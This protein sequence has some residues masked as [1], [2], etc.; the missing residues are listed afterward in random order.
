MFSNSTTSMGAMRA[1]AAQNKKA[2]AGSLSSPCT[3]AQ[4]SLY[5]LDTDG[6]L[7]TNALATSSI[8]GDGKYTFKSV[9][10]LGVKLDSSQANVNYVVKASGCGSTYYRPVT[11]YK[12]QDIS[13]V[14]TLL[15]MTSDTDETSKRALTSVSRSDVA[16]AITQLQ[17]L[18]ATSLS[19]L[20]DLIIADTSKSQIFQNL[21]NVS[22][23]KLKDIPPTTITLTAPTSLHE[24]TANN[25]SVELES[26]N[27]D[28][29]PAYEWQL[30]G[31][32]VATTATYIY[33]PGQNA[34]GSHTLLFKVGASSSGLIDTTK[35][36]KSESVSLIVANDYPAIAPTFQMTT[37][38]NSG[39]PISTRSLTLTLNTGTGLI[40]CATF[41]LLAI[42]EETSTAPAASDFTISCSTASTQDVSYT[43][44]SAG[45]GSKTLR[46]WAKDAAGNVSSSY[47]SFTL[48]LDTA[49]PTASITSTLA[50]TNSTSQSVTFVANDNGG[51][52]DH[53]LCQLDSGS[54]IACSS[55]ASYSSLSAGSHSFT[56]KAVDTAGNT[57]SPVSATWTVDL[58]APTLTLSSTPSAITNSL[59]SLFSFSATDSGGGTVAG[60]QCKVDS[61][62]Y[63]SCTSPFAQALTAGSHTVSVKALDSAGNLSNAQTYSWLIDVTAPTTS[64]ASHPSSI[65]NATTA[66]FSFSGADTGGAGVASYQCSLD[67]GSYATCTSPSAYSSLAAGSHSFAVKAVDAAGNLGSLASFTWTVDLTLPTATISSQP[68]SLIN[69]SSANFVFSG[70]DTGGG[71]VASYL[72]SLDSGSYATCTSPQSYSGL[73][74]G[75]HSFA[76][77]AVDTAGN[78]GTAVTSNWTIDLTGPAV[79]LSASPSSLNNSTSASLTF[80]ATDSGGSSVASYQCSL[81]SASYVTCSSP[82]AYSSLAQGVHS[83]AIKALDVLGNV[84]SVTSTSWTTDL[85]APTA[86]ISASPQ[87]L[88]NSTSADFT[89]SGADTGGGSVASYL[90]SLDSGSYGACTSPATYSS[91]AAGAHSFAVK[92][93]D[94]A[95]NTGTAVTSNW[96]IDLTTPL[97]SINSTPASITNAT[98]A[99][100]SFSANPPS[101]GS[102][103]GYL[104]S[105]D[106]GAYGSCSSPAAYSSLTAGSHSFA[107]KSVDNNSSQSSPVSFTWT[108]DLSAPT[109]SIGTTPAS[110]VASTNAS[111]SFSG[112]DTGGGSVA[113]Y[114][115]SIDSGSYASCASPKSYASLSEGSHTF[116]VKAVDT[117]G[118]TGTAQTST[119]TIDLTGPTVTLSSSPSAVN[120]STTANLVFSAADSGG[121]TV[122]LIQCSLDG[123][124]Y[125]TCTS[126]K[127]Y[128]SLSEGNHSVQIKATDSV[129]NFGAVVTGSW[130]TDLTAPNATI[131]ANPS[132]L[133]NSTSASFSFSGT[134]TGGG[135]VAS[136]LCSMDSGSYNSCSSPAAYSALTTGAH[137]FAVKAVD[138][139]GNTSSA[140]TYSWTIDQTAPSVTISVSPSSLNNLTGVSITFAGTDTGGGT[141]ASYLCSMDSGSYSSCSS[142]ASYSSLVEG[143]HTF[144]VKAVD[145]AGNTGSAT[146][147]SWTTDVTG[148]TTTISS[149]PNSITN[150]IS[151]SFSFSGVDTGGGSVASYQCALDG[152][153]YVTCTSP[154]VYT[155][156]STGSHSFAVKATDTAGNTGSAQTYSWTIDQTAPTVSI[157]SSPSANANSASASFAFTGADTGGGTVAS[158]QCSLD[159][160]SYSSCTSPKAYT[161]LSDGAHS[162]A[163]KATDTAGNTGSASTASWTVD[164]IAPVLTITTPSTNATVVAAASVSA[165]TLSGACETGITVNLTGALTSTASCSAGA[166]ST[167]LNLTSLSDGT[168]SITATQTDVAGNATS[169]I[170]T[171]IKDTTAPAITLT[172]VPSSAQKGGSSVAI[173]FSVTEANITTSQSFAVSYSTD[174]G[175]SWTAAGSVASTT[176]P[177]TS[178]A[179]SYTL[180]FP[181]VDTSQFKVK[182]TGSDQA[183][184]ASTAAIS[185]AFTV[186]STVPSI[187]AFQM[188]GGLTNV[189]LPT[190]AFTV[191]ASDSLSGV[192]F[193]RLS[194][195]ATYSNDSWQTFATTGNFVLSQVNGA[196]IVYIWVKDQAGNISSSSN[197]SITLSA[198]PPAVVVTSPTLTDSF[199][200]GQTVSIGWTCSSSAGLDPIPISS[201]Q[202]TIDDG[203]TFTTIASGLTNNLT[204]TSG[205]YNWTL[206]SGVTV[207]RLMVSCK[208]ISG[209]VSNAYSSPINTGGW[210]VYAGDPWYGQK[211][212]AASIAN[213]TGGTINTVWGDDSNNIYYSN[214]TGIMKIDANTGYVTQF[215]GTDTA[216]CTSGT[217]VAALTGKFTGVVILG[218]DTTR[219]YLLVSDSACGKIFRIS[220][221]NSTVTTWQTLPSNSS[222]TLFFNWFLT[223]NRIL[224]FLTT[225]GYVYKM[226]LNSQNSTAY[227]ITG[228]GTKPATGVTNRYAIGTLVQGKQFPADQALNGNTIL[229]TPDASTI[230]FNPYPL[231]NYVRYDWNGTGYQIGIADGGTTW[232]LYN[233]CIA[234]DFDN[235]LYCTSRS[236]SPA[237]RSIQV[238]NPTTGAFSGTQGSVPFADN[239]NGSNL[240]VGAM[241]DRLVTHYSSNSIDTVV[242]SWSGTWQYNH[243]AGQ[244]LNTMG[245]GTDRTQVG[246]DL[247]I[248]IKYNIATSSLWIMNAKASIRKFTFSGSAVNISTAYGTFETVRASYVPNLAGNKLIFP[249]A[250]ARMYVYVDT[251]SSGTTPPSLARTVYQGGPCDYTTFTYNYPAPDGSSYTATFFAGNGNGTIDKNG[252]M[253]M[254]S[255]GKAYF[256]T[257]NTTATQ[258]VLIYSSD[259]SILKRIAGLTGTSGYNAGD[260][261]GLASAALLKRVWHLQEIAS[262]TH[263]GDLLIWDG[264]LLRMITVATD[265]GAPKIY[266]LY[267]FTIAPTYVASTTFY[268]VFYDQSSEISGQIGTGTI[269]YSD[270]NNQ[271]HKFIPNAAM[272]SAT[273]SLYSFSGTSLTGG[274]RIALHPTDGLLILQK[275]KNRILRINP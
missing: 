91:L 64:L 73:S 29:V 191:S 94:T 87:S 183:G 268:D 108:V 165:F 71:S 239:F 228:D 215:A 7:G 154:T 12:N 264:D 148:P 187:T 66:S 125:S 45:D 177:L 112:A 100:F 72:C 227:A 274:V 65:T 92:A 103:T 11:D 19:N 245:N 110:L 173:G 115:C 70:A 31:V 81:D 256:G 111:F 49:A 219:Q 270:G 164:T 223:K 10:G 186:D 122:S 202:Y 18:N 184:N 77:K 3:S 175:S 63:A 224:I 143:S 231:G 82:V 185:S 178:A 16:T 157:T 152:G 197:Y 225:T 36:V 200:T 8:D 48:A 180:T 238:F 169:A 252:N 9:T 163:V 126:P 41:S 95:G 120:N 155:S 14:S 220:L 34:Q 140:Q 151:A 69:S 189:G 226:D 43:L 21:V 90:C 137:S 217:G 190:V 109:V 194:E 123:A 261:G 146:T 142:P 193:M 32:I 37:P 83:V 57:S 30:D 266:D 114:L 255:N 246:L 4:A 144:A 234:T 170:R 75:A 104:C 13:G 47:S 2:L 265:S 133:T 218:L 257:H 275:N 196:K 174:N 5:A 67:G 182:V 132:S 240:F 139:A 260:S 138:T 40:N 136:Y 198:T 207:F 210:S 28:Y 145:S 213:V 222:L 192:A 59:S 99:S 203:V 181:S 97:A 22:P 50:L 206:P 214:D 98:T 149:T 105:V 159:G 84:G 121:G 53:Y 51:S 229:A 62:S 106:S 79:T 74:E 35:P 68:A 232:K 42:T 204:S 86:S 44:S 195:T 131:T 78:T 118:N 119:W 135:T 249:G 27:E 237:G 101:G 60:Y 236:Q 243:V 39:A 55:P 259:G 46:L 211:N 141:V 107:V 113:S 162:F 96:T 167:T 166:W 208:S 54:F 267:S 188:A 128:S 26:W 52:I 80:S 160:G 248:D 272:T 254:H 201:V 89:F 153:S 116:A 216:G 172:S 88:T 221:S 93:V 233:N 130:A 25:Y 23:A 127:A 271:V 124:A 158:Y 56:V 171:F 230:W 15:V 1:P 244:A 241:N 242:P 102:I 17:G 212:V 176:G 251:Y 199:S 117:A 129:G 58:T 263:Q 6:S 161:S 269:Y 38:A 156:L 168:L 179:F 150:A 262:G 76:V 258:D 147:A 209:V 24:G 273:D 205:S 20:L 253:V 61:G 33:S 247:P 250:C 85:T 134:D 235:Y